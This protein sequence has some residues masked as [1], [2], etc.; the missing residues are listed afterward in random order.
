L[1]I[2]ALVAA[3]EISLSVGKCAQF[4]ICVYNMNFKIRPQ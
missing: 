4:S 1:A 2:A 3:V